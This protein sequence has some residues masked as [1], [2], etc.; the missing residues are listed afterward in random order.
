MNHSAARERITTITNTS[1]THQ[2]TRANDELTAASCEIQHS[3]RLHQRSRDDEVKPRGRG[4]TSKYGGERW[5]LTV[6]LLSS[7][8]HSDGRGGRWVEGGVAQC[9]DWSDALGGRQTPT[10]HGEVCFFFPVWAARRICHTAVLHLKLVAAPDSSSWQRLWSLR[11]M[12]GR[13]KVHIWVF[14]FP[15]F[16]SAE[17]LRGALMVLLLSLIKASDKVQIWCS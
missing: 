6:V 16:L 9:C 8:C 3:W 4:K 7:A 14:V 5:R 1:H 17:H 11:R 15:L 2:H 13:R 10:E 12:N